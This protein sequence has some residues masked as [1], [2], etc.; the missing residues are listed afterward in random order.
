M[1]KKK[2]NSAFLTGM[3]VIFGSIIFIGTILWLGANQFLKE[4]TLYVTYFEGS[5]E[6]LETGSPVKYQGVSVGNIKSLRLAPDGRLIEAVMN[7]DKKIEVTDSLRVKSELSGIA[8]GK[9]LQLFYPT[10]ID[11]ADMYPI[12]EFKPEHYYIRSSPSGIDEIEIAARE[13]MD[14][15]RQLKINEISEG[16]ISFLQTSTKFFNNEE[17]YS[18]ISN[19]KNAS[20]NIDNLLKQ[21]DSSSVLL[22]IEKTSSTLLATSAKLDKFAK[23]LNLQIEDMNLKNT[24][25]KAYA[26][27][28]STVT[29]TR[30]VINS[31]GFRTETI[32][33]S[34]NEALEELKRTNKQLRKSLQAVSDN[35]SQVFFSEP[36]PKEK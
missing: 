30:K 17:L 20:K 24:I 18:I 3:F 14:N 16:T 6:G 8:G 11:M 1:P 22:N 5:V 13:V 12:P 33:F 29:D 23:N 7:I 2:L 19:L 28:D 9:F 26:Q 32:L 21:A 4:N 31:I 36:P 34:L 25:D 27:Y 15:L 35:P 10:N